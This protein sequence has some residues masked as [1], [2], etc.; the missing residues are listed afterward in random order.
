VEQWYI[1]GHHQPVPQEVRQLPSSAELNQDAESTTY[2][3][4]KGYINTQQLIA[5][6]PTLRLEL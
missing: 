4:P 1:V 3:T 5:E 2:I 6:N